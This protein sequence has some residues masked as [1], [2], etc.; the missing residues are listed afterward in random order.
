MVAPCLVFNNRLERIC[1]PCKFACLSIWCHPRSVTLG[2]GVTRG[3]P[4]PRPPSRRH[5]RHPPRFSKE[6][7][8]LYSLS[9]RFLLNTKNSTALTDLALQETKISVSSTDAHNSYPKPAGYTPCSASLNQYNS[10]LQV[11]RNLWWSLC[12]PDP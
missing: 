4:P 10:L 3:G 6:T 12:R 2:D 9:I 8:T 5:C 1:L 11:C 7:F